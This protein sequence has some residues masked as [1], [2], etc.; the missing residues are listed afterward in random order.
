M[1]DDSIKGIYKTLSDCADIS[2]TGGGI[3]VYI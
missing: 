3:A 1:R 2:K